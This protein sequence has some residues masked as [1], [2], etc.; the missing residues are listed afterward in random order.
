MQTIEVEIVRMLGR[1]NALTKRGSAPPPP[2]T[3]AEKTPPEASRGQGR[4]R[5]MGFLNDHGEMSQ[6][7]IAAHLGIRPQS[8]S[9]LLA[10]METDGLILRRQ[11][12]EDKRQ[13]LVSLTE[14]GQSRVAAFRENHRRQAAEFL[15][16]LTDEEKNTLA[17]LLRKL[18]DAKK[19]DE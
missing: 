12:P 14:C 17:A 15:E 18:I 2:E 6:S 7:Q 1:L 19:E 3:P 5:L 9:E 13:T 4:G 11:S 16:P 8:L 10:K